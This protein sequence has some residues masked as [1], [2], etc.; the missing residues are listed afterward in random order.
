M[1]WTLEL[2]SYL[3]DAPWPA[4]KDELIDYAERNGLPPEIIENLQALEEDD[5]E[6]TYD[7]IDEVWQ[8]APRPSDFFFSDEDDD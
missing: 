8:D 7:S 4:T 1:Y 6:A 2:A 3:D 5:D